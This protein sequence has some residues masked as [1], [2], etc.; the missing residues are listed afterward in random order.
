MDDCYEGNAVPQRMAGVEFRYVQPSLQANDL[1]VANKIPFI[2]IS[3]VPL[4]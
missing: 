3:K 2:A 1:T 4:F